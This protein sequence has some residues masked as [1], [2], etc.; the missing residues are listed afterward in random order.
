MGVPGDLDGR[1][2]NEEVLGMIGKYNV[3][4]RNSGE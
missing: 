3:P 2:G 4:G 1:V